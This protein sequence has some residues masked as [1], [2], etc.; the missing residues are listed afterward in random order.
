MKLKRLDKLGKRVQRDMRDTL[1]DYYDAD[2]L[3]DNYGYELHAAISDT[4]QVAAVV[5]IDYPYGTAAVLWGSFK[6]ACRALSRM[7]VFRIY[8]FWTERRFYN[9]WSEYAPPVYDLLEGGDTWMVSESTWV[10]AHPRR[11][12]A[13]LFRVAVPKAPPAP[14]I[15]ARI[16][17]C[18][19]TNHRGDK[20]LLW[21]TRDVTI[22]RP[23]NLI[24]AYL[25]EPLVLWTPEGEHVPED[26][27]LNIRGWTEG[28][29][30]VP[31][32]NKLSYY[33]DDHREI[34][35]RPQ[36]FDVQFSHRRICDLDMFSAYTTL[37]VVCAMIIESRN[38]IVSRRDYYSEWCALRDAL[39]GLECRAGHSARVVQRAWRC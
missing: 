33:F 26:V 6:S 19:T 16:E 29:R 8:L 2:A 23:K 3:Y 17:T 27:Y 7:K 1:G 24:S 12:Q 30:P 36:F 34:P 20:V 38:I 9:G 39:V 18:L 5:L 37:Y 13:A 4:S 10:A 11:A 31:R 14:A 25:C 35:E 15:C 21:H 22:S 32:A 28:R